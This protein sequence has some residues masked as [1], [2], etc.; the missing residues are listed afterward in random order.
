MLIYHTY[1]ANVN[2][3]LFGS[4]IFVNDVNFVVYIYYEI[5]RLLETIHK[6]RVF[7]FCVNKITLVNLMYIIYI[8]HTKATHACVNEIFELYFPSC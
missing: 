1:I 6:S 2:Y 7:F 4:V 3:N 8:T 5:F